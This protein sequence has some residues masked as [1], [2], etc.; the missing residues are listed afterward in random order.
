MAPY[1]II[2]ADDHVSLRS[3]L[4]R[5]WETIRDSS[6]VAEARDE[7]DLPV[8]IG[9]LRPQMILLGFAAPGPGGVERALNMKGLPPQVESLLLALEDLAGP[10]DHNM[11]PIADGHMLKQ[12]LTEFLQSVRSLGKRRGGPGERASSHKGAAA[13]HARPH[14]HKDPG[15]VLS[16][17]EIQVLKLM[18]EGKPNRVIAELF[19]VSVRTV[20][21]HRANMKRKLN[22]QSNA[23]LIRYAVLNGLTS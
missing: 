20:E 9:R 12:P 2:L 7:L 11:A 3:G 6:A 19:F 1:R 15:D 5:L 21:A 13:G 22:I 23:R 17:R 4:L 16:F 10:P 8:L 14:A 18:S